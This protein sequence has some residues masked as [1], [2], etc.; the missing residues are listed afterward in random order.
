[1][2][3]QPATPGSAA[4]PSA[5][6]HGR[7]KRTTWRLVLLFVGPSLALYLAFMIVPLLGTAR[8]SLH[9]WDGFSPT[10]DFVGLDNFARLI[11]D[12]R[13]HTALT[14]VL[15]W[16]VV[17]TAGPILIAIPLSIVLW[18]GSRFRT[19]FRTV[20]FLPIVL[21]VVV[22]GIVWGWIYHPLYGVLNS[23]LE[24]VG[25]GAWAKGW[26]GD[27]ST[28]LFAVILAAVWA[29]FGFVVMLLLAGLQS[30]N[31]ELVDA[32]RVDGANGWQRTRHVLLPG[33]SPVLTFVLVI[34]L[35]G[36][37]SVF[38]IV[39]VM[40]RAG[41]GTASEMLATYAYSTAFRHNDVGYGATIA[42]V[43]AAISLAAAILVLRVRERAD[44]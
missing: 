44:V 6:R 34:T 23:S 32:A 11:G 14:H 36:A 18:S 38:D 29:T 28:A 39:Y 10:Q 20:Y 7:R 15:I 42:L 27:P 26:L 21:P 4:P 5:A 41:P 25:L 17:G 16:A 19:F 24:N 43:I 37:F 35:I 13:F 1:M 33:I 12:R 40:T 3:E 30:I 31:L 2:A 9:S 8:L 22:V